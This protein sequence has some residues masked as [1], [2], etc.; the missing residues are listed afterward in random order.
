MKEV[1]ILGASGGIGTAIVKAFANNESRLWLHY[2]QG[3]EAKDSLSTW[4]DEQHI[5]YSW[6]QADFM[7]AKAAG[8][9]FKTIDQNTEGIDVLINAIGSS[10]HELFQWVS[11]PD[12]EVLRTINLDAFI[13]TTQEAVSRMFN[14]E[15]ANIVLISSV[16]GQVGSAMEVHYSVVKA[17]VIGLIKA[18]SKELGP[19]GIRVNGVAPGWIETEMNSAFTEAERQAFEAELPLGRIGKAEEVASCVRFLCSD[20]ASYLTGQILNPNGG[21]YI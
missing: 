13:Y 4:L 17:G 12:W 18:L 2:N 6:L 11:Q 15:G 3:S 14:R 16:W 8:Q 5:K 10:K 21:L 9:F 20:A 19:S 1:V 7:D